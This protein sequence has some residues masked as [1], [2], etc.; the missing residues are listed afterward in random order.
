MCREGSSPW[1]SRKEEGAMAAGLAA[2][3]GRKKGRWA[4]GG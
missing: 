1:R 3:K 2:V 4:G